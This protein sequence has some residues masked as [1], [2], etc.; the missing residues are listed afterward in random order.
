MIKSVTLLTSCSSSS[1]R[2]SPSILLSSRRLKST[3]DDGEDD[4]DEF[5]KFDQVKRGSAIPELNL[6]DVNAGV[7]DIEE[8]AIEEMVPSQISHPIITQ[9]EEVA[10][11]LF[12]DSVQGKFQQA[13][14]MTE[15]R[16]L[17]RNN[18]VVPESMTAE[19]WQIYASFDST[20]SRN[21]YFDHLVFSKLTKSENY[22]DTVYKHAFYSLEE[23]RAKDEIYS[24][25]FPLTDEE[26][27]ATMEKLANQDNGQPIEELRQKFNGVKYVYEFHKQEDGSRI[28]LP[29]AIDSR[30]L[31]EVLAYDHHTKIANALNFIAQR[32]QMKH[33]GYLKKRKRQL[34]LVQNKFLAREKG[35]EE[36]G[37]GTMEYGIGRNS[38]TLRIYDTS[39]RRALDYY[40][41]RELMPWGQNMV[42]D[43]GH[44]NDMRPSAANT[45]LREIQFGYM[46]LRRMRETFALHLC[47]FN[48]NTATSRKINLQFK[49]LAND[50]S[51]S[52]ISTHSAPA[53]EVFK[54]ENVVLLTPDSPNNLDVYRADDVYVIGGLIGDVGPLTIVEAKKKGL[55]HA[56]FPLRR[57]TGHQCELNID[58]VMAMCADF[59]LCSTMGMR[60]D[61]AWRFASRWVPIRLLTNILRNPSIP[62]RLRRHIMLTSIA[63]YPINPSNA[64]DFEILCMG[65]T[66]YRERF[67]KVYALAGQYFGNHEFS[68]PESSLKFS[69]RRG[70][71]ELER[72][73]AG[74][75]SVSDSV[76]K[77]EV[78]NELFEEDPWRAMADFSG[79]VTQLRKAPAA[80]KNWKN[81]FSNYKLEGRGRSGEEWKGNKRSKVTTSEGYRRKDSS[82]WDTEKKPRDTRKVRK[83][84][85]SLNNIFD[86]F[87]NE[88]S[89]S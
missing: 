9:F 41:V 70:Y 19:E 43:C 80:E 61:D 29:S 55:R 60:T 58:H 50:D 36:E 13:Q 40:T 1:S 82:D 47:N 23:I 17:V 56:K 72:R 87:E 12:P 30:G 27:E 71:L 4:A 64:P 39:M 59:K 15:I 84:G 10:Q 33:A 28:D 89:R 57:A 86:K 20:Y 14:M 22:Q 24:R 42:I 8:E 35:K 73:M 3:I 78:F 21:L 49:A 65:P 68:C 44:L 54:R 16:Y 31:E 66:E 2:S 34:L 5:E 11:D 38:V 51:E 74:G 52:P 75:A 53:H 48:P 7:D 81:S 67:E 25:D 88:T 62:L 85:S 79:P 83:T 46:R 76:A 63:K 6:G 32:Q 18:Y 77:S 37:D 69:S 26:A 45:V